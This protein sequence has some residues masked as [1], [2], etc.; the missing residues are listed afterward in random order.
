ML[1]LWTDLL[2]NAQL[3]NA[4]WLSGF[5]LHFVAS[6]FQTFETTGQL[7]KLTGQ[8]LNYVMR[9]QWPPLSYVNSMKEWKEK[10]GKDNSM[11]EWQEKYGK[12]NS[13]KE[14]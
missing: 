11:K 12:D 8:N 5:L 6:H 3:H 9:Y 7:Q 1:Y 13:M 14:W 10:Y 2:L 4:D